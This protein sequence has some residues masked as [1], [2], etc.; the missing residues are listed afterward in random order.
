MTFENYIKGELTS[1]VTKE[2]LRYGSADCP[3]AVAQ[4]IANR[5]NE[6]WQGG[7]WLKVIAAAPNYRGTVLKDTF[8]VDPRSAA[9]RQ[10]LSGVESIYHGTADDSNVNIE[11]DRGE[12]RSLYYC[13]LHN[14]TEA[15]FR[16]NILKD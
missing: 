8:E 1:F 3:L 7:D 11:D 14:V 15:W 5:V 16:E 10:I 13:E 9:F 6:G 2:A 4:V 12:M